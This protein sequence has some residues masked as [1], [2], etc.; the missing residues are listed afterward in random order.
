[1]SAK[2]KANDIR[3]EYEELE[4]DELLDEVVDKVIEIEK[5]K[6]KLRK[7][8]NPHTP[9]SKQGFDKP[10][11]QGITVGRKKGKKSK[12]NGKTRE[13]EEPMQTI[14]VTADFNPKT[15]SHN[16]KELEEYEDR[17][18]IN[19]KIE[20]TVI[21]YRVHYYKD[22][23][24]GEIF[25]ATHPDL[26]D[27]GMFG[28]DVL[29][30]ANTLHFEHRVPY[31]HIA[32]IFTNV[33]D[34]PMSTPTA[35]DICN[36]VAD[37]LTPS[38]EKMNE[39]LKKSNVINADETGSNQNGRSEWL[40]AFFTSSLAFFVFFPQRGGE[41]VE[42]VLGKCF[43]GI[44]GCDGW[45]TYKTYSEK[46]GVMLQRCWAHLIREVKYV[47]EKDED[48]KSAYVWVKDIFEDVKKARLLKRKSSRKKKH[49]LL[50]E[51]LNRWI[52]TY[53]HYCKMRKLVTLVKNGKENWFT[54][55]LHLEIEPT[56]NRAERGI[57][58]FVILEKIMGCL[59]SEQGKKTTQIM[60]S[61]FGTWKLRG[62]NPYRELRAIL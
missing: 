37:K 35:L 22:L 24:T 25:R 2:I 11:A 17:K 34:I 7:Y 15:G 3:K 41:I 47:C 5:L 42:K 38:Y 46:Y 10:Q 27:R 55:V 14:D 28:K 54:C 21:L 59:R 39:E 62:L 61:L 33:F 45:Q 30:F 44:I 26:P 19:F 18:I 51:E 23:D 57:R 56:N 48:L 13:W 36:R 43:K 52:Q 49:K 8:E 12:H 20:K 60:M 40:W 1:L 31:E 9:P 16:I 58:K 32:N 29:A 4:K 53:G 50:V 6:R